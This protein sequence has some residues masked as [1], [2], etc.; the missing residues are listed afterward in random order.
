VDALEPPLTAR[1]PARKPARRARKPAGVTFAALR[2]LA[3]ALPGVE[4]G[5]SYGTP[6]FRVRKK[7]LARIHD[8]TGSLVLLTPIEQKDAL[9][10]AKPKVFHT[11]PHYDGHGAVL[12]RLDQIELREL[13]TLFEGVWREKAPRKLVAELDAR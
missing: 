9:L 13:K 12:I 11:T 3:L 2:K 8:E 4:E 1:K 5:S 6:A 7:L 10:A